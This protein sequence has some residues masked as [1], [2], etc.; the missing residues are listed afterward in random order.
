MFRRF[1]LVLVFFS[2]TAGAYAQQTTVH[3]RF[4]GDSIKIGEPI[5]Y[6][7][8]ARHPASQPVVFPDSTYSFTPFE[9]QGKKYF[10]TSTKDNVSLDSAVYTLATYEIDSVQMLALP[11][12]VIH[13]KDC[14]A[15]YATPDTIVLKQLTG[16]PPQNVEAKDLP[17]K[18]NADYLSVRW[19]FNYPL[20]LIIAGVI[21][22]VLV[23]VWINFGK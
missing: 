20:A 10:P 5:K 1:F 21:V 2:C 15:V 11:V 13:K 3:G 18:S 7:L 9:I 6:T 14:T 12:F 19:I 4:I 17:L 23:I 22:M 16:K 8:A